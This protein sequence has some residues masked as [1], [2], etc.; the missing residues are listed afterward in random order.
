ML[1]A[2]MTYRQC[3]KHG[4]KTAGTREAKIDEIRWLP[5]FW[6]VHIHVTNQ[7]KIRADVHQY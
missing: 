3:I 6:Q 4:N 7:P 2:G 1:S 5:Y